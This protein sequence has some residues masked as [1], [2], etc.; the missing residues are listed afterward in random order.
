MLP[1]KNP[2]DA[3]GVIYSCKLANLEGPLGSKGLFCIPRYFVLY[4][5]QPFKVKSKEQVIFCMFCNQI[6]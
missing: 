1:I 2:S 3:K 6:N 5:A 4:P